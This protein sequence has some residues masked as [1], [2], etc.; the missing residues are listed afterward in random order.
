MDENG[1]LIPRKMREI[2]P[3]SSPAEGRIDFSTPSCSRSSSL[4]SASV[5]TSSPPTSMPYSSGDEGGNNL[6]LR[7]DQLDT[8]AHPFP[9]SFSPSLREADAYEVLDMGVDGTSEGVDAS[10]RV[11]GPSYREVRRRK[12]RI[13]NSD[14]RAICLYSSTHAGVTQE[15]MAR[16][17]KVERSTISKIIREKAKWLGYGDAAGDPSSRHR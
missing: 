16:R 6:M 12:A 13:S 10:F 3:S 1:Q 9:E 8:Y 11:E 15:W 4:L 7:G 2:C 17:Y 14:R 5:R